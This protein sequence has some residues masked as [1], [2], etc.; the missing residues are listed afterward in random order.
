MVAGFTRYACQIPS[1]RLVDIILSFRFRLPVPSRR[2]LGASRDINQSNARI[3]MNRSRGKFIVAGIVGGASIVAF[4]ALYAARERQV[5][6]L[7]KVA[8]FAS[9]TIATT[10]KAD[11]TLGADYEKLIAPAREKAWGAVREIHG[12]SLVAESIFD[13]TRL[14]RTTNEYL[15]SASNAFEKISERDAALRD[16]AFTRNLMA[17]ARRDLDAGSTGPLNE[18]A[19]NLLRATQNDEARELRDIA[20]ATDKLRIALTAIGVKGGE[21]TREL[22]D[23]ELPSDELR[24]AIDRYSAPPVN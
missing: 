19:S 12:R 23:I 20:A 2:S 9:K 1:A 8:T 24:A 11:R 21:L 13:K 22:G 16:L 3:N 17:A 6:R 15:S 10:L 5:A 7:T 18:H 14:N 4:V